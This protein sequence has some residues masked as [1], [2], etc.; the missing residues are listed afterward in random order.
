M[1]KHN[2]ERCAPGIEYKNGSCLSVEQLKKIAYTVLQDEKKHIDEMNK[3]KLVETLEKKF[4]NECN[5][6]QCWLTKHNIKNIIN[7]EVFRPIGPGSKGNF[8]W[9]DTNDIENTLKQYER[10]Y[11]DFKFMGAAP[12]DFDKLKFE[13]Y[14][15]SNYNYY[16]KCLI[17]GIKKIG[18]VFNLDKH[19]QPGS[20][21]VAM[22]VDFNINE[23]Y[24]FNST[25]KKPCK[26]IIFLME[27]LNKRFGKNKK[28]IFKYNNVKHQKK[29]SEC[30]IYSINFI[31]RMLKGEKFNDIV[32]NVTTDSEVNEC[33]EV[34]FTDKKK[35]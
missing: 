17:K 22:F 30:G 31:L 13:Q 20:H 1:K 16:E 2:N 21:W 3:T 10:V 32:N 5:S 34:Y 12:I 11:K 19:N 24:F 14:N 8:K 25:G 33:R 18:Y 27:T 6:Q 7:E 15:Y 35:L 23:C 4:K 26:Q 28:F 9:L 29:N